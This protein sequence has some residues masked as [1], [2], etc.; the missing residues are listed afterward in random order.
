M[1]HAILYLTFFFTMIFIVGC[2]ESTT[3]PKTNKFNFSGKIINSTSISV[4][5]APIALIK[6]GE[7]TPAFTATTNSS[8]EYTMENVTEGQYTLRISPTGY[9][10]KEISVQVSAIVNRT[11]TV[12]GAA[13]IQGRVLSSQTGQGLDSATV[14]FAFG[15]D[16][17]LSAAE[18]IVI[19]N[20]QGIY[21]IQ[22]A[23]IGNFT[24]TVRRTGFF[25]QVVNNVSVNSGNN[26]LAPTTIV[27]TVSS[28][29]FRIVLT[30]GLTP[31][32]LD[33][34]LTGPDSVNPAER[35][36]C[37]FGN[38][39][40]TGGGVSLDV[41]DVTSYGPETITINNFRN[42]MYRFSVHNFSDQ[43]STGASGIAN[44]PARVQVY[45]ASGLLKTYVAPTATTG[46][47]WR[48]FEIQV[49]GSTKTINDINTYVTVNGSGDITNFRPVKD[50]ILYPTYAF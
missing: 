39:N 10:Q 3:D 30:W 5:N 45:D 15:T 50:K 25:T 38:L 35:F 24:L 20:S 6:S 9:T 42:G 26:E 43:S 49:N 29:S 14:A 8:G 4:R 37:Y 41:D 46:N 40:P 7:T 36:H 32:D 13:N 2:E 27:S 17:S 16:T 47:T 48:V 31:S 1:K 23:P 18:L 21:A 11:D 12:Y 28:G 34:H 44:S 22:Q 33:A 19:T